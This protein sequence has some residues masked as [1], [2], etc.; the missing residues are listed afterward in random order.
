MESNLTIGKLARSAGVGVE[1][2]RYYQRRSL[3][4]TPKTSGGFRHY[5]PQHADRIRFIK[6]AQ[7]LGFSLN[8]IAALLKLNDGRQR[9][10][11]RHVAQDR[12]DQ[13]K[14]KLADLAAMADALQ[15]LIRACERT[16]EAKPCPI[17]E[18]LASPSHRH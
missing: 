6:R 14:R 2:V 1:T 9:A 7:E 8:E 13:I 15:G 11:V 17:I 10:A 16:G 4:P 18:T 12:L 3:I 5:T